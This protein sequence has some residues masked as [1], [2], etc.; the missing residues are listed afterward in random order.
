MNSYVAS[1]FKVIQVSISKYD[2]FCMRLK[3]EITI[4]QDFDI[5]KDKSTCNFIAQLSWP[6]PTSSGAVIV[7]HDN[8]LGLLKIGL[9][10]L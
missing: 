10:V 4:K 2:E 3:N 8:T 9:I 6:K 1:S 7:A 5:F